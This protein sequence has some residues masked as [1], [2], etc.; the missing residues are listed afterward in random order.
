VLNGC[1]TIL[2]KISQVEKVAKDAKKFVVGVDSLDINSINNALADLHGE[3]SNV[4]YNAVKLKI[5][6]GK[7]PKNK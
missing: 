2:L 5:L 4:Y 3:L 6:F 1:D 7:D